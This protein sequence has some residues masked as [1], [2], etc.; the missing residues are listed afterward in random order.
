MLNNQRGN[1]G[2]TVAAVI[3]IIM[4]I[5]IL[6]FALPAWSVWQQNMKGKAKL[7]K[8][9]QERQI[10][11]EQAKAEKEAA[12]FTAEAIETVGAAAKK[13]PEYRNQMF[14]LAF[15]EAL[16]EGNINQIMY[17]PTEA[18]IPITEATR[19]KNE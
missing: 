19:L 3:G 17:V 14:I 12:E 8:A 7:A 6:M 9:T 16:Q 5:I 10:L 11:I 1:V 2:V 18:G 13:Y 4:G 15:S